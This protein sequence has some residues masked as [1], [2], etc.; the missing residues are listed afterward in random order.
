[1][2]LGTPTILQ[3]DANAVASLAFVSSEEAFEIS[4]KITP[5]SNLQARFRAL[6]PCSKL[7]GIIIASVRLKMMGAEGESDWSAFGGPP[8]AP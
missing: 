1:M 8:S 5:E 6:F 3:I 7:A 4:K 2:P